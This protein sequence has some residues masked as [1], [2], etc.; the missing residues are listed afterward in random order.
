MVVTSWLEKMKLAIVFFFCLALSFATLTCD[1]G[2]AYIKTIKQAPLYYFDEESFVIRNG[3]TNLVTSL[4]FTASELRTT[5]YCLDATTNYQ[6]TLDIKDS[7]GDGWG[8]PSYLIIEGL[9]GNIIFKGTLYLGTIK[10][11]GLTV[12]YPV[13][14]SADWK[15]SS[16]AAASWTEYSFSDST[17]SNYNPATST[18]SVIGTQYYRKTFSAFSDIAALETR[19]LYRYGVVAYINGNEIYRDNMPSGDVTASTLASGSY[20]VSEYRGVIR[21]SGI[22]VSSAQNVLAVEVHFTSSTHEEV[23]AFNAWLAVYSATVTDDPCYVLPYP[24]TMTTNGLSTTLDNLM[25][26]NIVTSYIYSDIA[27]TPFDLTFSYSNVSPVINGIEYYSPYVLDKNPK[28]FVLSGTND[29]I[30]PVYTDIL[31]ETSA[32]FS[33]NTYNYNFAYFHSQYFKNHR[34]RVNSVYSS[35]ATSLEIFDIHFAVCNYEIPTSITYE[36]NVYNVVQSVDMISAVPTVSG[37]TECTVNPQLPTGLTLDASTC[38]V[39]GVVSVT[40][41][42]TVYTIT[43]SGGYTGTITITSTSCNGNVIEIRRVY[44]AQSATNERYKLIDLSN[45]STAVEVGFNGGQVG[46]SEVV[47]RHCLTGT[48]YELELGVTAG[49]YWFF[50]SFIYINGVIA[51]ETEPILRARVDDLI[52]LPNSIYFNIDYSIK[53][54]EQWSYKTEFVSNW[55]NSDTSGWLTGSRGSFTPAS[56]GRIQLFKK[57]FTISSLQYV[58]GFSINLRYQYGCIIYLNNH[59]VFRNRVTGDLSASSTATDSYSQL[60][61]R[62]ITLPV[63]TITIGS[64]TSTD[65]IVQGTN[66][67]AIALV[68]MSDSQTAIDFDCA[69]RL[70][71]DSIADRT[72]DIS[73]SSSGF[74]SAEY[75]F[76]NI[77]THMATSYSCSAGYIEIQ[78]LNDRREWIS[79]FSFTNSISSLASNPESVTLKAR[80]SASEEWTTIVAYPLL[81]WWA[82]GQTKTFYVRN[83]KPYNIYRFDNINGHHLSESYCTA[84]ITRIAVYANNLNVEVPALSYENFNAYKDIE[85][86]EVFPNSFLYSEYTVNPQLPA[87]ISIDPSSG[88]LIGTPT[89][90]KASQVYTVSAMSIAGQSVSATFTMSVIVC[91]GTVNLI[92]VTV[93]SDSYVTEMHYELYSGRGVSGSPIASGQPIESNALLYLDYCLENGLYTFRGMDDYGDGWN[94]PAGYKFSIDQGTLNFEMAQVKGGSPGAGMTYTAT[95]FSSYIP[96]QIDHSDWKAYTATTAVPSDWNTVSF[97]DAAWET[98]KAAEIK[99]CESITAYIRK[100]FDIPNLNDY[101]VLNVHVAYI[102]GLAAYFNGNLVARFNLPETFTRET[103]ATAVH[104]TDGYS[105]FHIIL[106]TTGAVQGTNVIAFEHHRVNGAS[107][108]NSVFFEASGVFGVEECSTVVDSYADVSSASVTGDVI[109]LFRVTPFN[110]LLIPNVQGAA[111]SWSIENLL[112][113]KF[114]SFVMHLASSVS[115]HGFS[116]YGRFSEDEQENSMF[117]QTGL[118]LTSKTPNAYDVP[119]GIAGFKEYRYVV[120]VPANYASSFNAFLFKYCKPASSGVCPAIGNYPSVGEG[121]ISPSECPYGYRG[122]SFRTCTNGVLSDV[123]NSN[124]QPKVPADLHYATDRFV[125]VKDTAVQSDAPTYMNIIDEFY[126]D[127]NVNLPAGLT[128]D[129][130]TGVISGRPSEIVS[131]KVFTIYG[132][133]QKGSA[134]AVITITIRIGECAADGNFAKTNVGETAIYECSKQGSFVGTVK[135]ACV[136]GEKDGVWDKPSGTC[137]PTVGIIIIVIVVIVVVVV[138]VFIVIRLT[139]KSKTVGSRGK[140]TNKSKVMKTQTKK[141]TKETKKTVKV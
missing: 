2:K 82:K 52:G 83:N 63:K 98:K 80:N 62:T 138:V 15:T 21:P 24:P 41:P 88:T 127:T 95:T 14:Q 48:R 5:E 118:A 35:T 49:T 51:E 45:Q 99:N 32:T 117:A 134:A 132:R 140:N 71:G 1:E 108:V 27:T 137:F 136:L 102:G 10:T 109:D 120:D 126:L 101:Q 29:S 66:T 18:S 90:I 85:M 30:N 67:I 141:E 130:K 129:A 89:E 64:E 11:Y 43:A 110:S 75:A 17:W 125:F 139:K 23:P 7:Y 65:Y 56:S 81:A 55:Y 9:Y 94:A 68:A 3:D 16:E 77:N 111:I 37:F 33:R 6:Y 20:S 12:N 19:L 128:L 79:S 112:G 72:V 86:A 131:M 116:L 121:Q 114:N 97:N 106:A 103:E 39:T 61:Y 57:A 44:G 100:T 69:V 70:F 58:S 8:N 113:S 84:F 4:P 42:E 40:I 26:W 36:P 38:T 74:S 78:F 13:M 46:G 87:G 115:G 25:D 31:T 135:R 104:S 28:N 60:H 59:E 73:S 47:T 22:L 92:T 119:L 105:N 34:L 107:S 133:N 93:R 91:T 54:M 53:T 76:Q 123:D 124:C 122:Y 50:G 96:F